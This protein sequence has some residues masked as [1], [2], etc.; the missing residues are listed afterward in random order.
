MDR[1]DRD[2]WE[3]FIY[4][5]AT[6]WYNSCLAFYIVEVNA[7]NMTQLTMMVFLYVLNAVI[8]AVLFGVFVDQFIVLRL[9]ETTKQA[10]IDEANSV[11]EFLEME[12][13]MRVKIRD[14][15]LE[16]FT[17]KADQ[18]EF[19][20]FLDE[21]VNPKLKIEVIAK[22]F[23]PLL[24]DSKVFTQL[25]TSMHIDF[26]KTMLEDDVNKFS[27][28][29]HPDSKFNHAVWL[30]VNNIDVVHFS[31][32]KIVIRQNEKNNGKMFIILSGVYEA[33]SLQ[34]NQA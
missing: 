3:F 15:F 10:E 13:K 27:G 2:A 9:K 19:T 31:P 21:R 1:V 18:E 30:L 5:Y 11:M 29:E 17:P 28:K 6:M 7:R 20:Q 24:I 14:Y 4:Q 34:Y 26:R 33:K 22:I 23:S 25:R 32:E 16:T 12:D 8:N